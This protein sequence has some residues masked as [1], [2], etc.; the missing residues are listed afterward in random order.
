MGLSKADDS[1]RDE[2]VAWAKPLP[3]VS[4]VDGTQVNACSGNVANATATATLAAAAGLTNYVTGI[5][6]FGA[7]A[8]AGSI[9]NVTLTNCLGGTIT[10][11][12]VIP[13]GAL[14]SITP[15]V[16]KFDPP[17]QATAVNLACVL[18]VPAAGAGNTNMSATIHGYRR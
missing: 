2:A 16:V 18:S 1:G 10:Y 3:T 4:R 14:V 15:I 17:L 6:V 12:L 9:V 13:A 7:G 11:P 8:T 5:E